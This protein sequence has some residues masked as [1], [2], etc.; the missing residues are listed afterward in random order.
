MKAVKMVACAL[1]VG[2]VLFMSS[3][4]QYAV[5]DEMTN[6]SE[7]KTTEYYYNTGEAAS[8]VTE[9]NTTKSLQSGQ[10]Q[11]IISGETTSQYAPVTQAP[12]ITGRYEETTILQQE[13]TTKADASEEAPSQNTDEDYASY[14]KKQI[15]DLYADALNRTRSYQGV[16]QVKH[17]ETFTAQVVRAEP[18][19]ALVKRLANYIVNLVGSEGN[20]ELVFKNGT[21][22]NSEGETIPV[23][24][25]QRSEFSL[26]EEGVSF[27]SVIKENDT[28]HIKLKLVSETVSMGQVPQHNASA[29]G[30]LDTSDISVPVVTM[31]RVDITYPGSEIDAY[32]TSDGFIKNVTYTI[33]MST[34]AELSGMGMSG[35]G[36]LEGAQTEKW[37]ISR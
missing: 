10:T 36:V 9:E 6:L 20:Q 14:S 3:C 1:L 8:S 35:S 37:V 27:A 34:Y 7:L 22:V 18:N 2:V 11:Q 21:A 33:N 15:I 19:N 4:F 29:I 17:S 24:L 16:L 13:V 30:Y 26:S 28:V 5:F 31:H 25:P 23:L 32:I 12:E